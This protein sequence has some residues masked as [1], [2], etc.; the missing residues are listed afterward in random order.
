MPKSW[1]FT[2]HAENA[3]NEIAAWTYKT[4][5][6]QQAEIYQET[7]IGRCRAIADGTAV[8]QSCS[9]LIGP[10]IQHDIRFVRAGEHFVIYVESD[11]LIVILDVLHTRCD[12]PRKLAQLTDIRK[13]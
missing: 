6:L 3:L 4:F 2:R 10:F 8:S 11:E 13:H 5:G 1:T 12:L 7:L 9:L